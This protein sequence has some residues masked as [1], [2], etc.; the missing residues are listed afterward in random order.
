MVAAR[1]WQANES[2][3]ICISITSIAFPKSARPTPSTSIRAYRLRPPTL[4]ALLPN[5][6]RLHCRIF[7]TDPALRATCG[8][9]GPVLI[10]L[11]LSSR[12]EFTAADPDGNLLRV[13]YDFAWETRL[14]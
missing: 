3:F 1:P 4:Q 8:N 13:F 14:A 2:E 5:A 6:D 9:T 10:W 7:L 11:N 12:H